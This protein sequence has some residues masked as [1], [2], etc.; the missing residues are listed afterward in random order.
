[1][2]K[3]VV[4]SLLLTFSFISVVAFGVNSSASALPVNIASAKD[5]VCDGALLVTGGDCGT[6]STNSANKIIKT[7]TLVFAWLL[8]VL[9]VIYIILGGFKFV[10][11]AGDSSQVSKAKNTIFFA[12]IGLVV[13]FM[14]QPFVNFVIG[15]FS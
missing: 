10:T 9:S 14:A 1:M 11:S 5:I 6:A 15:L 8:G 2:I 7:V 13:A 12:I 4:F 3:S